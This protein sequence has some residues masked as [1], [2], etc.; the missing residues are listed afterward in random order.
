MKK[1]LIIGIA[2]LLMPIF[3]PSLPAKIEKD[4]WVKIVQPQSGVYID[5][6][7]IMNSRNYIFIGTDFVNVQV[8]ASDNIFV[9]YLSLNDVLKKEMVQSTWDY[10]KSDGFSYNFTNLKMGI[11]AIAAVGAALDME[12]P[13]AFD[14]IM[15]VI[16]IHV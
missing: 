12:E 1:L 11:Y 5:G 9:V 15:P 6:K 2:I 14:W 10:D 13:I 7:K 4:S 3:M 16:I 8:E